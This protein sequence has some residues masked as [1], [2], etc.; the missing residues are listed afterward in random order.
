METRVSSCQD[1][2][3]PNCSGLPEQEQHEHCWHPMGPPYGVQNEDGSAVPGIAE[4][5]CNCGAAHVKI[6]RDRP[7]SAEGHGEYLVF[8]S[9]KPK[10]APPP[11]LIVPGRKVLH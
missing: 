9:P 10:P 5:C 6:L 4:C 11:S 8:V 1:V 3:C 7:A 2:S